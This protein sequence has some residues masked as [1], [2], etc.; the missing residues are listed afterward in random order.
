MI[1]NADIADNDR[2]GPNQAMTSY[3]G[4]YPINLS[5]GDIL[6]NPAVFAHMGI[7]GD[8]DAMQ[9]VGQNGDAVKAGP[10]ADVPPVSVS[11]VVEEKRQNVS[12][13]FAPALLPPAKKPPVKP[14]T[15]PL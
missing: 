2:P 9:T 4:G 1:A 15:I 8:I 14:Q 10:I 11:Q 6:I 3:F 5:D 12:D 13:R 7:A